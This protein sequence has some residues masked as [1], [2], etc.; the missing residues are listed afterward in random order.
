MKEVITQA[1]ADS[2][3]QLGLPL[4]PFAVEH[5]A[6]LSHGDY[7]CNV[8][9]ILGKQVNKDPRVVADEL[10][11]VLTD[12]IEY[13][14][15]IT[16]A[17]PGF[18]NFHLSRD[19]FAAEVARINAAP[20]V[21]GRNESLCGEEIIFEYTS[22]NLFKPLHIGN[23][24]GNIIGEAMTRLFENAGA[25]VH[26][27]NYPSDIGLTVAKGVWG[28]QQTGGD[29]EDISK[30]GEAYRIGNDAYEQDPEAKL[31]IESVNRALYAGEDAALLA[32]RERG[33][34]TSKK[35]LAE[36]CVVLGTKFD[37]EIYES[38]VSELGKQ[39][40]LA[41]TGT[42]FTESAGAVVFH[43][44]EYGLHTR[45]FINSQGLPTYEAKDLGNFSK[46][47]DTYPHWTQSF[48]VTG[49]E[50]SEYFK[51][52]IAAIKEVFPEAKDKL[53]EH[54][55][56]GFLTLTTGK[57]SSRKGNVLTGESLLAEMEEEARKK[58]EAS[59]CENVAELTKM[60]AVAALKYQILRQAPGTNITFNKEQ[61]LSFEGDSGP[62]LQYTNARITSVLEKAKVA[63]VI[64]ST[65]LQPEN[66]YLLEKI[67]Y[68]FEE[69]LLE[70]Q[71]D[72]APQKLAV[73]LTELAAAFNSF[74]AAEKIADAH[75][76]YAPYK[77]ALSLA[78]KT[79]LQNGLW[80]LAIKAPD[81]M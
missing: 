37:T 15:S 11:T 46:K 74:Y 65:A 64:P 35:R 66:T 41:N 31:A 49:N 9:M 56:T 71:S 77:V 10:I 2:L 29:P 44:E 13:V 27:V 80:L 55:A 3:I 25:V 52:I 17:G 33:L 42:V 43:G 8:A 26:R 72:R 5:P 78:V 14:E 24:V 79:T 7:A 75:D 60:V 12:Q 81:K 48:V 70:A 21:W 4:V 61:A 67:L 1:I 40:A 32:L 53:V 16:I 73:F 51:V 68:Q 6:D 18:I 76:Q 19:F 63:G 30:L 58:A 62:Y 59:R 23:L 57:M 47:R 54:I 69:V 45:V 39:I 34:A 28:L 50:Q 38:D 36:L 22:P 20:E